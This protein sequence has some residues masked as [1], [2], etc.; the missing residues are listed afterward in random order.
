MKGF[1]TRHDDG[2]IRVTLRDKLGYEFELVGTPA[3]EGEQRGYAVE[4]R[5]TA[6]P[7]C[8]ALPGDRELGLVVKG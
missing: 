1:L 8:W 2:T 7:A 5:M 6:V 3:V 4:C